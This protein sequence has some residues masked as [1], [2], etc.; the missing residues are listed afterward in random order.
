MAI[1]DR[2]LKAGTKLVARY[3]GQEHTAEV[4]KTE[5]GLRY[6]LED[7]RQFKSPSSA[8]SAVMGGSACNGWRF[9]SVAG[10]EAKPKKEP[11]KAAK[12]NGNP[13]NGLITRLEDGREFKSP[14]SAGSA[15]MGGSA[16]NGWRFW[17]VAGTEAAKPKAVK[18]AAKKNG[19]PGNGLISRLEDGRYFCSACQEPF[20]VPDGVEPLGCPKGHSPEDFQD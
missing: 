9:W 11:R 3:K 13:G 2:S 18:K 16:C 19:N 8:G 6:R 5:E 10:A 14:S 4:V 7:G 15:V 12:K 20:D 17:S 1:E